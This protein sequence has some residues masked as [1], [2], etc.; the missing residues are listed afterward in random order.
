LE[1]VVFNQPYVDRDVEADR[2]EARLAT[3]GT[4]TPRCKVRGCEETNP[5]ALMGAHP[6]LY[7]PLHTAEF[8]G[9]HWF[10][11]HHPAGQAND[12]EHTVEVPMGDHMVLSS[13]QQEW[14]QETLRNPDGSPLLRAAA[15]TRGWLDIL[16]LILDRTVGWV[17]RFLERLDAWLNTKLGERWWDEFVAWSGGAT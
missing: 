2:L 7:C 17:P 13:Y 3:L 5:F 12:A 8:A 14:P 11:R 16:R 6:E 1:A 15:A 10:E 9:R 4:H